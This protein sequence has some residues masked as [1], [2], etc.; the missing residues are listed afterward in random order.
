[1]LIPFFRGTHETAVQ[2]NQI[3]RMVSFPKQ[4]DDRKS[5]FHELALYYG[6]GAIAGV[7]MIIHSAA[8]IDEARI[9]LSC[10]SD[11]LVCAQSAEAIPRAILQK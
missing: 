3:V 8:P 6:D 4:P 11:R 2:K 1:M 7:V 10:V 5:S 9:G